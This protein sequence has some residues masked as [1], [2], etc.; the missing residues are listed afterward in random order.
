[1]QNTENNIGKDEISTLKN[2]L[3]WYRATYETRSLLGIIKDRLIRVFKKKAPEKP[4][5]TDSNKG[6]QS[7]ERH[8]SDYIFFYPKNK[9]EKLIEFHKIKPFFYKGNEEIW[10]SYTKKEVDI[11]IPIYNGLHFLKILLPQIFERSDIPFRLLLI[12]DCS[13]DKEIIPFLESF[14]SKKNVIIINNA[15]NLG[16]TGSVNKALKETKNDVV[17]LNTD[18][19]VPINWLSRLFNPIFTDPKVATVTPFS[20]CAT[21]ASFPNYDDNPIFE[22]LNVQQLDDLFKSFVKP[23]SIE[24]PTGVGFCM[25]ISKSA[26]E[27]VGLLDEEN[28]PKGYG[29]EV[30]WCM[31]AKNKGLK[32]VFVPNLFV[33]H[34]HGGSFDSATKKSLSASHQKTLDSLYPQFPTEV[35]DFVEL[36]IQNH[37]RNFLLLLTCSKLATQTIVYFD[38]ELGGGANLYTDNFISDN[39]ADKLIICVSFIHPHSNTKKQYAIRYYYKEHHNAIHINSLNELEDF[40]EYLQI[41]EVIIG[42]LITHENLKDIINSIKK[43]IAFQKCKSKYLVHDYHSICAN[44]NLMYQGEKFCNIP[45]FKTCSTC[46][47]REVVE[48]VLINKD[49]VSVQNHRE[50]LGV[51]LDNDIDKIV[52]FS[53][54]SKTLLIKAYPFL[55]DLK[56]QI[57]PHKV[58]EYRPINIGVI[59]SI[60]SKAK[61]GEIVHHIAKILEKERNPHNIRIIVFGEVGAQ[62]DHH[63]IQKSGTYDRHYLYD[64]ILKNYIDVILIPSICSETFSYTTTEAIMTGLPLFCF[65]LGGQ[66]DQVKNYANGHIIE[67]LT[68]EATL[69]IITNYINNTRKQPNKALA[70]IE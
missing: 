50:V 17:L 8:K 64:L 62:F 2:E 23:G 66:A 43:I 22:N 4:I 63:M 41:H 9:K 15:T 53:P 18:T 67:E 13:P 38:H 70:V 52:C 47:I 32:N 28:F 49:F 24:M 3:Q 27:S 51:F 11:V 56:I 10:S 69:K 57:V 37:V 54:S 6:I 25:A 40:F 60:H 35:A 29:E 1:M 5:R 26:L 30:D 20:N 44:F 16:F 31:R 45:D 39:K 7:F 33:Y 48:P 61:G 14:N 42:S 36:S 58:K 46:K 19:E 59:G 34:K 21:I 65:N 55:D 68:P 12:N